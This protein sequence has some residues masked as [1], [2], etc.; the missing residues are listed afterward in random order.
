MN[1]A[2]M[3]FNSVI[4]KNEI[5]VFAGKCVELGI[6]MLSE[7]SQSNKNKY[8]MFFICGSKKKEKQG[9]GNKKRTI[10]EVEG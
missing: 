6:I 4:N 5:M 1:K 10:R 9:Y 3:E 7:I 8:H 2:N